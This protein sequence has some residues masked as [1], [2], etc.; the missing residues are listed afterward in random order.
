M[1]QRQCVPF[2]FF[3]PGV[4]IARYMFLL[5]CAVTVSAAFGQLPVT[6]T[7][8]LTAIRNQVATM[9]Q[10]ANQLTAMRNQFDKLNQ[11]YQAITGH[12][13]RG[14][15]GLAD[16]V[17]SVG[18]VPGSWQEV[19]KLQN[20]GAYRSIQNNVDQ[21]IKTIPPELFRDPN[22]QDAANYKL[23]TDAVRTAMAGG[24]AL[25][26]QVQTNLNNLLS[27]AS[28]IEQTVNAKDA[29]DLQ[30]RIATE[31]G[32]LQSAMAK[33]SIMNLNL[34]ANVLNQQNQATAINQQRYN[35]T[36]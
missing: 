12:Y 3:I 19:V 29:S 22:G 13:G 15:S 31:N 6:V 24:E 7:S 1:N 35:Q 17:S 5:L 9:T 14:V 33:L 16:A 20:S 18:V 11:Q 10:W 26:S 28:Q 23:T 30:N 25:Y 27:L 36:P 34:Q 32:L 21:L 4:G 2:R 8:D